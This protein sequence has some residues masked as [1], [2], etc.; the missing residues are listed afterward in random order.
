M[1]PSDRALGL[2]RTITRR[3]FV[4]GVGAS[5]AATLVPAGVAGAAPAGGEP[6]PPRRTGLRGTHPGAFEVAHQ[7]RD[8]KRWDLAGAADTGEEYDL[9]VVGG[10]LSGLAAAHFYQKA[11]GGRARVLVLDNHDDFG[12]HAKRNEFEVGGRLLALNGGTLN[13]ES[14]LRYNAPAR[15]L[16][17]DIGVDLARYQR[18][19][20]AN[21]RLYASLGLAEGYFFD[22]ETWGRDQLLRGAP[23]DAGGGFPAS[24]LAASPL[25]ARARDDLRRLY[26]P[27]QPDYLAGL[28]SAD[29]KLRLARMSYRDYLLEAARVDPS[30]LWFFAPMSQGWYC[31]GPDAVPALF[32]WN[33]GLPG[34]DGLGLEPTPAG[35]L[36]D[37]PGGQHGRQRTAGG[38]GEIHFPD[39]NAT[40]AR[41]LVRA[42]VP[43]AVPGRTM[44]DVG[45]AHV[46]YGR[47]DRPGQPVRVRLSSTAVHVAHVGPAERADAVAV[48]YVRDG[49]T[50]RVTGRGCVLACWNMFIPY[51]VPEL[52][53]PQKEAL[54]FNVKRPLVYTS[55][56][57]RHWRAFERL[58]L[59][60]ISTPGLYHAEIA[61]AEAASLGGLR[62]P[63]SPAEP[64]VLHLWRTPCAPGQPIKEQHRLGRAELLATT[65]ES[66]ERSI[67]AQLQRV[68]G[69]GGFDAARD[70]AAITVNRWPHGYAYSYNSLYDPLEWVFT[71]SESRPNVVARQPFGLISI[72]NADAAASPHTDAAILEGW[73]AATE[74]LDRRSMPRLG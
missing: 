12:G 37:L 61:L 67:R 17:A 35:V 7:L 64:I 14:P 72:A 60:T 54:A 31:A 33:D 30:L 29:K 28:G 62:H 59:H 56:A 36:A 63:Q 68:L 32:A 24:F 34:F 69:A 21:S 48:H 6:Y 51:L 8:A 13:V 38:G 26:D 50:E 49:R 11:L 66:F 1:T 57:V 18:A 9:V 70:I 43:E 73:R 58:G 53:A 52:P 5:L 15:T 41:L 74:A 47:L 10:G 16:L 45:A 46:D 3:D 39:G 44:E 22:R 40:I 2:D 25:G 20:V 4:N 55:V 42:L 19:N 71:S 23:A 27:R 65:F